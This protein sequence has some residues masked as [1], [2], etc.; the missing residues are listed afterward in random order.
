[1][2]IPSHH[3]TMTKRTSDHLSIYAVEL[4][5]ILVVMKW[6]ENMVAR[7]IVVCSDSVSS[8]LSIKY[9]T[10]KTHQEILLKTSRL[11]QQGREI[12]LMWVQAHLGIQG[13]EQADKVA[14]EAVKKEEV[15]MKIKSRGKKFNMEGNK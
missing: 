6:V 2:A 9:R 12:T 5:A 8:I 7:K 13:N 4:S 3:I 11:K 14:K 1:M 15:E 10:A